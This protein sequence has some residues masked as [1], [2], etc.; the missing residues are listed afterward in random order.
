MSK[1]CT[2]CGT[3]LTETDRFCPSCGENAP[4]E[5]VTSGV[6]LEKPTDNQQ[7]YSQPYSQ[8]GYNQQNP[9]GQSSPLPYAPSS[10]PQYSP[11]PVQEEEMTVGKWILTIIVTSLGI[12]GLVFLFIW[13]FGSGPKA[14]Q[15]YCKAVLILAAIGV[16]LYIL[17]FVVVFAVLG[18]GI[19]E[20]LESADY[21]S[22]YSGYE[23][24][25]S[26]FTTL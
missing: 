20:I 19:T 14:R 23:M 11:Y 1:R 16:A 18:I 9:Y 17:L 12:I 8:P 24:A 10:A 13:G 25:K 2:N 26:F 21:D 7:Q 4:Q 15:N 22:I 3:F 6:S 5:V